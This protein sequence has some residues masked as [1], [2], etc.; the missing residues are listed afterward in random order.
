MPSDFS[1]IGKEAKEKRSTQYIFH[2]GKKSKKKLS[3]LSKTNNTHKKKKKRR[4]KWTLL[5]Q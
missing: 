2:F 5:T 1:T 4:D 3:T